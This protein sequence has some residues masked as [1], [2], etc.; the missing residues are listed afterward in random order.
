MIFL[1]LQTRTGM[2]H[3]SEKDHDQ[4]RPKS[5]LHVSMVR[6]R[7]E[8][9]KNRSYRCLLLFF[10]CWLKRDLWPTGSGMCS[11]FWCGEGFELNTGHPPPNVRYGSIG[12]S[13]GNAT[14]RYVWFA[15]AAR[16]T[17]SLLLWK[18]IYGTKIHNP[19]SVWVL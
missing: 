18:I 15:A 17:H 6:C 3:P 1:L 7:N 13:R 2:D 16:R 11:P 12:Y 14:Q 5:F 8:M 10:F 4:I 19:C 9:T